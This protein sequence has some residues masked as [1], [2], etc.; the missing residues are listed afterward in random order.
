[1]QSLCRL[2]T[3]CADDDLAIVNRTPIAHLARDRRVT[4]IALSTYASNAILR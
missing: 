4:I 3:S 1:M 2:A